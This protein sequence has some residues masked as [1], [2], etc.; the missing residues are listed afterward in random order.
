MSSGDRLRELREKYRAQPGDSN[1]Q[2]SNVLVTSKFDYGKEV[3]RIHETF[4]LD[5]RKMVKDDVSRVEPYLKFIPEL[6]GELQAWSLEW[7]DAIR[8]VVDKHLAAFK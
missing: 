1:H 5:W 6:E 7:R 2:P 8:T 4:S 3:A